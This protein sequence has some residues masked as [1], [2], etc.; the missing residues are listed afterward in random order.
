MTRINGGNWANTIPD[1]CDLHCLISVIPEIDLKNIRNRI[2]DFV[3]G[4]KKEDP[5]LDITVQIPVFVEPQITD[6][7]TNFAKI[8]KRAFKSVFKEDREFKTFIPTSD[9]HL[10]QQK[11]IETIL[12]G[13]LRGENNY[14]AQDEFVY[15]EDVINV[16]KIFAITALNYLK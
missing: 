15:I 9:A 12:I 7:N 16:T 1:N 11:G 13:P 4:M 14:H 6:I 8:V 3:E 5:D 10:F 2:L